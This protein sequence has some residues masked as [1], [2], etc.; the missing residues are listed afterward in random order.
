MSLWTLDGNPTDLES[1]I[2]DN[3]ETFDE[4]EVAAIRA[5][6]PG[7]ERRFGGGAA[8]LF[9]LKREGDRVPLNVDALVLSMDLESAAREV[10]ARIA[11]Q[12]NRIYCTA[13]KRALRWWRRY[14]AGGGAAY[15]VSRSDVRADLYHLGVLV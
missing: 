2:R 5:M 12:T 3:A 6:Q 11:P 13:G 8:P 15:G 9:V 4:R 14:E 10:N 1:F 7:E